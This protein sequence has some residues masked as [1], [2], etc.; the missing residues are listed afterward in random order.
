MDNNETVV[1]GANGGW[2]E[3]PAGTLLDNYRIERLLGRGGMGAVYLA[4]HLS[5]RKYFAVKVLPGHLSRDISFRRRFEAEGQRMASLEHP[6]IVPIH[7][8]GESA[9]LRYFAMEYM[10]GGDLEQ[11]LKS[12]GGR[13]PEAKVR[14]ILRQLLDALSYA[15]CQGVVHRDLKPAN[16]L[17]AEPLGDEDDEAS[18]QI[19][20]ADFGL[21]QVVGDG[22]MK[23]LVEQTV[24]ASM[25]GGAST[26]FRASSGGH[27]HAS[28]DYAGTILYMAPEVQ[29]GGAATAQS[30][31]YAVGVIG[32]YLLTGNRPIGKY[33]D[34][35]Q[36][37]EGIN[38]DWDDWLDNM[39]AGEPEYRA[40]TAQ[41]AL[42]AL[43]M[44]GKA[45]V[46][47]TAER[48]SG[49]NEVLAVSP[50][51]E[52][53]VTS[54]RVAP[55]DPPGRR[56]L[57]TPVVAL[58]MVALLVAGGWFGYQWWSEGQTARQAQA[59]AEQQRLAEVAER[60]EVALRQAQAKED[61]AR[62]AVESAL[63]RG[64]FAA[65]R[66]ALAGMEADGFGVS[67]LRERL[68]SLASAYE[69]RIRAGQAEVA[70]E[71]WVR[72][73]VEDSEG[74]ESMLVELESAWLTSELARGD[75]V[76]SEALSGYERVLER[77]HTLEQ[78]W[79]ER[80]QA[81]ESRAQ[82]ET[83]RER[84][85]AGQAETK[86]E[87]H[88]RTAEDLRGQALS[89]YRAGQFSE[90]AG[91]F[92]RAQD[93][94]KGALTRAELVLAWEAAAANWGRALAS[95]DVPMLEEWSSDL[96]G[97]ARENARTAELS[98]NDPQV[99]VRT[100]ERAVS[101]LAQAEA[102]A[103]EKSS[104]VVRVLVYLDGR[105][106]TGVPVS[107]NGQPLTSGER[108]ALSR[109]AKHVVAEADAIERGGVRF[110]AARVE[111]AVD[112][113][114]VKT[115]SLNLPEVNPVSSN[116]AS[117]EKNW[118]DLK[119]F[120]TGSLSDVPRLGL[121]Q[122][123]HGIALGGRYNYGNGLWINGR[124]RGLFSTPDFYLTQL[125]SW[126][127]TSNGKDFRVRVRPPGRIEIRVDE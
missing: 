60:R 28:P 122:I 21:A 108:M 121:K 116:V 99:G 93:A 78:L 72:A 27:A 64:D 115:L 25:L 109:E 103:L 5:L 80:G 54:A 3:L 118:D 112:W 73:L 34:A 40:A 86:A 31:L 7:Y 69:A 19:K 100:Y 45:A 48:V 101:I 68:E 8:S 58:F 87:D 82:M 62:G 88:W 39:M 35:S 32:Y 92:P 26:R 4:E 43:P 6:G 49:E 96:L 16:I 24:A 36:L 42:A 107:I 33:R 10:A 75:G 37:V 106:T 98:G 55:A 111:Q 97:E 77:S 91:V 125:V 120:W 13:L 52:T 20:I 65:A 22:Y 102:E 47:T 18:S 114:G 79:L 90:S 1:G 11:R 113:H 23:S 44:K 46:G 71:R 56:S 127:F 74:L 61:R 94:Y 53:R 57:F 29:G 67:D 81:R 51:L 2:Q 59:I 126:N 119:V 9:N 83:L 17:L 15:H 117:I 76:W 14:D 85:R 104:P 38:S 89:A 110:G 63:E 41:E 70:H 66:E 84:A 12:A 105:E 50:P 95:V 124:T 123:G 30:D